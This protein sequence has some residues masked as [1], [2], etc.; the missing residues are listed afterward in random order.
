MEQ[1]GGSILYPNLEHV[2]HDCVPPGH[3]RL[4][5]S[6]YR[7][8]PVHPGRPGLHREEAADVQQRPDEVSPL[9]LQMLPLVSGEVHAVHQQVLH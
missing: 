4:R 8:H 1:I 6:H 5:V 7:H 2:Q 3:D 9:V